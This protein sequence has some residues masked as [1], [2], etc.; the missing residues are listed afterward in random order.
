MT[1]TVT[2]VALSELKTVR[3]TCNIGQCGASVEVRLD[4]MKQG[5]GRL[6]CPVCGQE[7]VQLYGN[8]DPF[9]DLAKAASM[10]LTMQKNFHVE[11]PVRPEIG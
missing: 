8:E 9:A 10:L 6:R 2:W 7:F 4:Q 1:E 5:T 3:I 11:F